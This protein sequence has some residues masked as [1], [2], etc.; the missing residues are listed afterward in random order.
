MSQRGDA[1]SGGLSAII[2]INLFGFPEWGVEFHDTS[3]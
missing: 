2:I 1:D 3:V